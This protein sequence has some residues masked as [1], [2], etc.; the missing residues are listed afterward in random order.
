MKY[1]IV[2]KSDGCI[3]GE[4]ESSQEITKKEVV[5]GMFRHL[6]LEW[7]EERGELFDAVVV[8]I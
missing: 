7:S 3:V 6:G 2:C 5:E 4:I 8:S 1:K